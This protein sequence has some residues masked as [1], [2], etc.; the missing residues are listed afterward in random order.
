MEHARELK[1]SRELVILAGGLNELDELLVE[2]ELACEDLIRNVLVTKRVTGY[3]EVY[4]FASKAENLLV[5][6]EL[7]SGSAI[8]VPPVVHP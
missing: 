7:R 4:G 6:F 5:T 2:R 3:L 1:C 8:T